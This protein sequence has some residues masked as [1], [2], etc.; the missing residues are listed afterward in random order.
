MR[1]ALAIK[2]PRAALSLSWQFLFGSAIRRCNTARN[3][4]KRWYASPTGLQRAFRIACGSIGALPDM[5]NLFL[6]VGI[7]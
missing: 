2:F 6:P 1:E 4:W 3:R 7:V 5:I